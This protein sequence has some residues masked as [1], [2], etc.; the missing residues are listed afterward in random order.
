MYSDGI[1]FSQRTGDCTWRYFQLEIELPVPQTCFNCLCSIALAKP[2]FLDLR[3]KVLGFT[4]T[5]K[6]S[7]TRRWNHC[8]RK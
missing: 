5:L 1:Y 6:L 3:F 8:Q 7:A 4:M 2:V